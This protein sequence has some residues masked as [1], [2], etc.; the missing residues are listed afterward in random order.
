MRLA[1]L[2]SRR[3]CAAVLL[4]VG[5]LV[6]PA[7]AVVIA[8]GSD[9]PNLLPP[10]NDPGWDNVGRVGNASGVYLGNRWV[11]TANHVNGGS[12]RLSDGREFAATVGTSARLPAVG[13]SQNPDLRIFR[14]AEDP[15]LPSLSIATAAPS[16]GEKVMMIGAGVDRAT[17]LHGWQPSLFQWNEVPLRNATFLGFSLLSTSHMRWG[18][19]YVDS[20]S[21]LRADQTFEF[22]T[23]FDRPSVPFEAQAVLGDSGG[24][25]FHLNDG[26]WELAGLMLTVQLL[27]NQPGGTVVFGDRTFVGDLAQYR[28]L[29]MTA[30]NRA[31]PLW[32]NQVNIFDVN[33]SGR[34]EPR[35]FLLL[36]NELQQS[37]S[38]SLE[39]AP[40][41]SDL[42]FDVNG[43]YNL[44]AAD[45]LEIAN[46]LTGGT[47]NPATASVSGVNF[48]SEPS[49]AALA[50]VGL[51]LA[52]VAG[53]LARRRKRLAG[54]H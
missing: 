4:V 15:G 25:V 14:L 44:T 8:T 22:S 54:G 10:G 5:A 42:L 24:G 12:L 47:A 32:Q 43:D 19:N 23:S 7:G 11:I 13:A 29:I 31:E 1:M 28:T 27:G 49:S 17:Q 52:A 34:V 41:A 18:L 26:A 46:A 21:T 16:V 33:H 3:C 37:G 39:G 45:A 20:A 53:R 40:G 50:A 30:I 35:D 6:A 9:T 36:A 48:V 38:R 51:V 2:I